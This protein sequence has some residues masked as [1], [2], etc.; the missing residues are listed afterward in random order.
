MKEVMI[1]GTEAAEEVLLKTP[2]YDTH[3]KFKGKIVPFAGYL[4]PVQ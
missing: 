2:R 3:V 1:M 4:L